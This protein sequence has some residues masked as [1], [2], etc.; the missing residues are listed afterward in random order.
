MKN[1]Q[2]KK[3]ILYVC[4]NYIIAFSAHSD[5]KLLRIICYLYQGQQLCLH[6]EYDAKMRCLFLSMF[7]K[8]CMAYNLHSKKGKQM[9]IKK[10]KSERESN[11]ETRDQDFT[12]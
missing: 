8:L 7:L 3:Y 2:Y 5:L 1:I 10:Q 4:L 6:N 11:K 9:K 12:S